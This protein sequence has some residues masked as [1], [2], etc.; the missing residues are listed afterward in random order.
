V[1]KGAWRCCYDYNAPRLAPCTVQCAPNAR[2]THLHQAPV[3]PQDARGGAQ[4]TLVVG[5]ALQ[6]VHHLVR[7]GWVGWVGLVWLGL[8]W[9]VGLVFWFGWVDLAWLGWFTVPSGLNG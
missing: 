1:F 8:A 9:L 6:H 4:Q 5:A 7:V 2:P 3:L